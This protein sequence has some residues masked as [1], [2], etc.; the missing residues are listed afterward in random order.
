M[1]PNGLAN[2]A[3]T[4][5]LQRLGES[6][7]ALSAFSSPE[8]LLVRLVALACEHTGASDG[9]LWRADQAG[10]LVLAVHE[11][12]P[13]PWHD[14]GAELARR[15]ARH[16]MR[17]FETPSTGDGG[18]LGLPLPARDGSVL[19]VLLLR[20]AQREGFDADAIA[21]AETLAA[22]AALA[23]QIADMAVSCEQ[24]SRLHTEVEVAR[25]IQR[26][27]L[28]AQLPQLPGY[29][30]HG[31]FQPATYA[32]GDLFD[33]VQLDGGVF[34]LLGDATGHGFGP[35]LSATQMQGMLRVA[36][37]LGA[38]LDEACLQVNNQL[39]EDLPDDRFITAFMGFLDAAAH[40]V[41][42]HSAGQGPI[43]HFHADGA[44]CE[45]H[46][47]SLFPVGVM[48]LQEL[49]PAT[50]LALAPGDVLALISDGLYERTDPD[51]REFGQ[52]RVAE[53]VRRCHALPASGL[54][55]EL[56]RAADAFAAG[57]AQPDDITIVLV[58]RLAD[59]AQSSST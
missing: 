57:T 52:E 8:D 37:R 54:C 20:H 46:Q 55:D 30:L 9:A 51:N 59:A 5:R 47:P 6:A 50:T 34:L 14:A 31:H 48:E 1:S 32:G 58:R 43:L 38:G 18:V 4:T 23:L 7:N 40:E 39:V 26:S 10:G 3:A 28:P 41:R 22:H 35:A 13:T 49:P 16:R 53:V 25:E 2:D 45:W 12:D 44:R 42:F 29:D 24:A 15:C 56:M 33:A 27:T 11:L 17:L 21:A 36:F 19:G